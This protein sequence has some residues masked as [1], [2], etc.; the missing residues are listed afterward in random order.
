MNDNHSSTQPVFTIQQ[1]YVKDLSYEAP[2][3]PQIFGQQWQPD[4]NVTLNIDH[5]LLTENMHEVVLCPTL[6]VK[7]DNKV[8]C[9][10]EVQQAGI[11]KLQ[12]FTQAQ[13]ERLL[14][15]TCPN[16]LL[17]FAREEISNRMIKGGFPP[18]HLAP[19]DFEAEYMNAQHKTIKNE[20]S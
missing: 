1:I 16:I 17:P 8:L 5:Q 3:T 13:L 4:V 11:F 6:T 7:H 10:V 20:S 19:F 15:V 14:K 12:D 2:H 9:L 18:I